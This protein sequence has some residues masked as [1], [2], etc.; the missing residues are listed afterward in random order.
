MVSFRV[1]SGVFSFFMAH[2][3][4]ATSQNEGMT[5]GALLCI[6][7][8]SEGACVAMDQEQDLAN[9]LVSVLHN[10][11]Q[12][13][14]LHAGQVKLTPAEEI[15]PPGEPGVTTLLYLDAASHEFRHAQVPYQACSNGEHVRECVQALRQAGVPAG[16]GALNIGFVPPGFDPGALISKLNSARERLRGEE[17]KPVFQ[18]DPASQCALALHSLSSELSRRRMMSSDE[19]EGFPYLPK[20]ASKERWF[21]FSTGKS[22]KTYYLQ[23][24]DGAVFRFPRVWDRGVKVTLEGKEYLI[25]ELGVFRNSERDQANAAAAKG[26]VALG[27]GGDQA[28]RRDLEKV[29]ELMLNALIQKALKERTL[30][31][32]INDLYF[33]ESTAVPK[34]GVHGLL[35]TIEEQCPSLKKG[36]RALW[37]AFHLQAAPAA[38]GGAKAAPKAAP[39]SGSR[40]PAPR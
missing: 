2:V 3:V 39:A 32:F 20:G 25:P 29:N 22:R 23:R 36:T 30:A 1:A 4:F 10:G 21:A 15:Q 38:A 6:P 14:Q 11:F 31:T 13:A 33:M 35:T 34:G 27:Y 7:V 16:H 40:A 9:H 24:E 12:K 19:A 26:L 37:E 5:R 18:K 17:S 28:F 8:K